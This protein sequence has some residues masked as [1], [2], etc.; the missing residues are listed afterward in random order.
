MK[1]DTSIIQK[2]RLLPDRI[3]A[4]VLYAMLFDSDKAKEVLGID[5]R[6][7]AHASLISELRSVDPQVLRPLLLTFL[8]DTFSTF[9]IRSGSDE[10]A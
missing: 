6:I 8:R 7:N 9:D 5:E 10:S 2:L 3:R 1:N 4:L